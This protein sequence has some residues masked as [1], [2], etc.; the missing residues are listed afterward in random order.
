M[1]WSNW[2]EKEIPS[3]LNALIIIQTKTIITEKLAGLRVEV[4]EVSQSELGQKQKLHVILD[5]I[6]RILNLPELGSWTQQKWSVDSELLTLSPP[7]MTLVICSALSSAFV[8]RQPILQTI[9][10]QIRLLPYEQSDQGSYC[11][12]PWKNLVWSAL[13]YM[14]QM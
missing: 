2:L 1:D 14:K 13:E 6:N 9:W 8:L 3:S 4:P 5:V 12:L 10:S 7:V 11:L